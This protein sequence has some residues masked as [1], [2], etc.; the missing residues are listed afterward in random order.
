MRTL[1][2]TL[3]GLS[4][5]A[6]CGRET[7][8][9]VY[10]SQTFG[11]ATTTYRGTI[12]DM[13]EVTV[14][15][16][17]GIQNNTT[18]LIGGGVVGALLGSTIGRGDGRLVSEVVG[19]VAGAAGGAALQEKLGTESAIQYIVRLDNGEEKAIV[20]ALEPPL[21]V[22]QKVYVMIPHHG[23]ARITEL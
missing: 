9:N 8:S 22:G 14:K 13:R 19:G 21:H 5:L 15:N 7:S 3:L 20:Q 6:A 11:E 17:E 12:L 4:L 16:G 10:D 23:R 2:L 18:G 1:A